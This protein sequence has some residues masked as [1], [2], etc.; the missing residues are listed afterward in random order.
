MRPSPLPEEFST[1]GLLTLLELL[2]FLPDTV[3]FIKDIQGRYLYGNDTLLRRLRLSDPGA[4]TGKQASDVFPAALG[5]SYTQQDLVVLTGKTLTE[6]LELHL[7]MGGRS[8]WCLTTKRVLTTPGGQVIGLMGISR[9]LPVSPSSGS[10]LSEAVTFIHDHYAQPLQIAALA[11]RTQMSLLTF[12][13][14]IKRVYGVTPSQLLIRARVEAATRL[15]Q[16]TDLPVARIAVEC[17]YF[18]H[19]AFTRIFRATVGVTPRQYRLLFH[20]EGL[21]SGA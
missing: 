2:H 10:A 17:G 21:N 11:Q 15:L 3:A 5:Q 7:Y 19:S 1:P 14:Q 12:E 18:D 4:L 20:Q 13:R 6:H 9:D 16:T 8:G